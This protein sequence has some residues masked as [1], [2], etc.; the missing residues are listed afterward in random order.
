MRANDSPLNRSFLFSYKTIPG[1]IHAMITSDTA[2]ESYWKPV[3]YDN[4]WWSGSNYHHEKLA[5]LMIWVLA[6]WPSNTVENK[7]SFV[8]L[9]SIML[10]LI[11]CHHTVSPGRN[12]KKTLTV[13]IQSLN[14]ITPNSHLKYW[15]HCHQILKKVQVKKTKI[16]ITALSSRSHWRSRKI[17]DH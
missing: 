4:P 8:P 9:T 14:S 5:V 1:K 16:I 12:K 11:Q 17:K 15:F 10:W 13:N 3:L 7:C 2:R 6:L